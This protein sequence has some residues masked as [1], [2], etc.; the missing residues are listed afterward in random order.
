MTKQPIKRPRGRPRKYPLGKPHKR[1]Y[2]KRKINKQY[3][4]PDE[5]LTNLELWKLGKNQ[6]FKI[7]DVVERSTNIGV[8][9]DIGDNYKE[10]KIKWHIGNKWDYIEGSGDEDQLKLSKKPNPLVVNSWDRYPGPSSNMIKNIE[11]K[12]R[13]QI[14]EQEKNKSAKDVDKLV[15]SIEESHKKLKYLV[16]EEIEEVVE[17]KAEDID[18]VV[19]PTIEDDIEIINDL[20]VE[21]MYRKIKE[22]LEEI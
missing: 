8:I 1:K 9:Y 6:K 10:Y 22:E 5:N 19:D 3:I 17:D 13:K 11:E 7:G 21:E 18:C 14:L 12:R 4:T 15:E 2:T 20:S 16:E